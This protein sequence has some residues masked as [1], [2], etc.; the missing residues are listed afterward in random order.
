MAFSQVAMAIEFTKTNDHNIGGRWQWEITL[1]TIG[2]LYQEWDNRDT[3]QR[4]KITTTGSHSQ[5]LGIREAK[6]KLQW[7]WQ[8]WSGGGQNFICRHQCRDPTNFADF[9]VTRQG[10]DDKDN[11]FDMEGSSTCWKLSKSEV[12]LSAVWLLNTLFEDLWDD[13][14]V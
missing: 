12:R 1:R 3:K 13:D 6:Q 4:T 14:N 2:S 8:Y 11:P 10:I 9:L 5:E 7:G